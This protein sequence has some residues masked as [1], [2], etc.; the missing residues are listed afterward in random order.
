M[1]RVLPSPALPAAQGRRASL[2]RRLYRFLCALHRR[3]TEP[4]NRRAAI[5]ELR[6]LSARELRDVGIEPYEIDELVDDMLAKRR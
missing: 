5:R 4:W 2:A 6:R 3:V 1:H